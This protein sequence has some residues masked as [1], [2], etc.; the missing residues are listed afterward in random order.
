MYD[1]NGILATNVKVS[2]SWRGVMEENRFKQKGHIT[3]TGDCAALNFES[4]WSLEL[5][6]DQRDV[7]L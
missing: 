5:A 2:F 4:L 7:D 1:R 6:V 3:K